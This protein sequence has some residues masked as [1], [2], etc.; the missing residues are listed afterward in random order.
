MTITLIFVDCVFVLQWLTPTLMLNQFN[1]NVFVS[2]A[3]IESASVMVGIFGYFTIYKIPRRMSG[4]VSFGIIVACSIV[5]IFVWNQDGGNDEEVGSN[6]VVLLFVFI[7]ELV[8]SNAFNVY[9]IY[10]N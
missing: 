3:V 10:L 6:V 7:I 8:V 4:M 2:G 9:G 5:L 1:F